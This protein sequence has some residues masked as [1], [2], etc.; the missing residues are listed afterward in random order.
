MTIEKRRWE[1]ERTRESLSHLT[2]HSPTH[3]TRKI[4]TEEIHRVMDAKFSNPTHGIQTQKGRGKK[5][6]WRGPLIYTALCAM[7]ALTT[8]ISY[9]TRKAKPQENW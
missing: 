6:A 1:V 9:T 2:R 3:T 5:A 7:V 4:T 8:R